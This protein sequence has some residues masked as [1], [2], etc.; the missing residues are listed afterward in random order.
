[1]RLG[2]KAEL[3]DKCYSRDYMQ[4]GRIRVELKDENG[5][6]VND[7]I[8]TRKELLTAIAKLVPTTMARKKRGEP[9]K[10]DDP[11]GLPKLLNTKE[12]K[13]AQKGGKKKK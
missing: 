2:F 9:A 13:K 12:E 7:S 5:K 11:I 10:E 4:R 3:Q 6:P 8:T 1:M